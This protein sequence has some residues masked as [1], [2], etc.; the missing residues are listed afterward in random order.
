M[1]QEATRG[2]PGRLQAER[3]PQELGH[4]PLLGSVGEVLQDS[5][6]KARWVNSNKEKSGFGELCRGLI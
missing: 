5:Q 4:I 1:L 3:E 6:A 2:G